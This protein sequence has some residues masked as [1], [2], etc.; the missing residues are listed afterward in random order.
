MLVWSPT[1]IEDSM[2]EWVISSTLLLNVTLEGRRRSPPPTLPKTEQN[3]RVRN[4]KKSRERNRQHSLKNSTLNTRPLTLSDKEQNFRVR[5]R[6][7]SL[8][9]NNTLE[10]DHTLSL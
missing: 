5:K 4:R 2:L 9:Q 1:F 7:H 3:F 10:N 8:K 6:Q